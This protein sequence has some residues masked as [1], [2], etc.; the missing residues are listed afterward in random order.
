[1]NRKQ[2]AARLAYA[3]ELG[4]AQR[5]LMQLRDRIDTL[6]G[7]GVV[8]DNVNWANV[9]DLKHLNEILAEAIQVNPAKVK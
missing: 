9:G 5:N 4:T 8:S 1:M 2:S 3:T 7:D 6:I